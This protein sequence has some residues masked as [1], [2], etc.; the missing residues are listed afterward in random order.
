MERVKQEKERK[1]EGGRKRR[2]ERRR[3]GWLSA[4][5]WEPYDRSDRPH[6]EQLSRTL[7][8]ASRTLL[9][10]QPG[11][12]NRPAILDAEPAPEIAPV[13][14]FHNPHKRAY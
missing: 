9:A 5:S 1:R 8:H 2:R 3:V 14:G 4:E 11:K 7:T 10:A 12:E 6:Y 13:W